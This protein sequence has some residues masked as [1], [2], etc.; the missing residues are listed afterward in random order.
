MEDKSA[1]Q[2]LDLRVV[3]PAMGSGAFL[4]AACRVLAESC[5]QAMI[6][7]GQWLEADATPEARATLRRNVAE[8]CLY[9]VDLNPTAVQ[10]AR[11]SLWLTTLAADRP[12]TFLDHHL[13][14]GN[15]LIGARL[16]DLSRPMPSGRAGRA[17]ASLPLLD[18]LLAADVAADVL[19]ARLRLAMQPSDSLEAVR[20]KERSLAQIG[21]ADGRDRQMD[22]RRRRMVRGQA[23]DRSA[24][25]HHRAWS[26]NGS[27]RRSEP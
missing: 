3:D 20:H 25:H 11:L 21:R 17:P 9:G 26:A 24:P 23:L 13:A 4:V 2:I 27:L 14:A 10:L 16:A 22:R 8:R 5:E 18:D 19:P 1:D 12:L 6:R 15:S 7:D